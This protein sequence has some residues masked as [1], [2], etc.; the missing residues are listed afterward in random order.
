MC[1][2]RTGRAPEIRI[3][4]SPKQLHMETIAAAKPPKPLMYPSLSDRVQ[5]SFIDLIVIVV[6]MAVAANALERYE[7]EGHD[8]LR[9]ALFFGFWAIYEPL[10]TTLGFTLGNL[11]KGLR[12][13]RHSDPSKRINILQAFVRYVLKVSLGWVSFLT[14]HTNPERRAIHDIVAGSVVVKKG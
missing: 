5:S 11:V 12:V 4:N 1:I 7:D 13:R 2:D 10:C 8:W 14:I 9:M 3:L 6:F